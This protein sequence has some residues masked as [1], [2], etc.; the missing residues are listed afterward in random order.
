[1]SALPPQRTMPMLAQ[2]AS[3]P[4][5]PSLAARDARS[6]AARPTAP[7]G[8][9]TSF[10]RVNSSRIAS[11]ISSSVTVTTASTSSRTTGHVLLPKRPCS[12]SATVAGRGHG[13]SRPA[14]FDAA[15]SAAS[16]TPT[17]SAAMTRSP[18]RRALATVAMP[19]I[20]P[21]PLMGTTMAS[22]CGTCCR[23]SSAMVPWPAITRGSLYGCT[24]AAPV[25]A[26]MRLHSASRASI[27]GSQK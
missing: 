5:P 11:T 3:A 19:E 16:F 22:S 8:S 15:V 7:L 25:S 2:P 21:P 23:N 1:M 24:N 6:T 12:P 20:M 26:W 4:P 27:V 14:V 13:T 17:G 18:E 10:A 9:T